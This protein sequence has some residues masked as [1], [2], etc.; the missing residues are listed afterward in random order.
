MSVWGSGNLCQDEVSPQQ[1]PRAQAR[2]AVWDT[3]GCEQLAG[4]GLGTGEGEESENW[5][6][7]SQHYMLSVL[8]AP[9]RALLVIILFSVPA[10]RH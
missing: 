5:G 10:Q 7:H 6:A 3:P 8:R 2:Q 9:H 1:R 4:K